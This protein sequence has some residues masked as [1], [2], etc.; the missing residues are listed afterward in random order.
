VYGRYAILVGL[1][2]INTAAAQFTPAFLQNATYWGDGKA[3]FDIYNAEMVRD[4]QRYQFE[5]LLI[6]T[7]GFVDPTLLTSLDDPKQPGALPTIRMNTVGTLPRGLLLEQRSLTALWRMDFMSLARLS[8]AGSD[9]T[10][11]VVKEVSEHRA[12]NSVS[13]TYSGNTYRGKVDHQPIVATAKTVLFYDELPL[14]VRTI[15][16]SKANGEFEVQ[17][18]PS[19]ANPEKDL[20][21]LRSAII[22]W[23]IGERSIDVTV[24]HSKG[25]DHLLLDRD[26]PFLLREWNAA[27]GTRLKIKNSL[28]VDYWKYNKPGDRERAL[29]DPMLRHPD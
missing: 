17:L 11:N 10:G 13:W 7:P 22:S 1:G 5:L 19:L 12:E 3:E 28:K 9:G 18:A 24:R 16:F 15:D 6:F 29:K 2:L 21:E 23:K 4:G 20:G 14:R 8:F 25:T 27:D 26:F